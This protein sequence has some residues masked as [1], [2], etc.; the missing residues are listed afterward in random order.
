MLSDN[1]EDH[2]EE[3]PN[4]EG[5]NAKHEATATSSIKQMQSGR[6]SRKIAAKLLYRCGPL[7]KKGAPIVESTS[8]YNG[9]CQN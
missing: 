8:T 2:H 9:A 3:T 6:K 1:E 5:Q 7:S 4:I